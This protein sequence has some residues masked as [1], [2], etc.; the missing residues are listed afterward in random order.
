MITTVSRRA[1]FGWL[2]LALLLLTT[3]VPMPSAADDGVR[4]VAQAE[5][6]R[7]RDLEPKYRPREP[8]PPEAYNDDYFFAMTRGVAESPIHPAGKV[9]LYVF[10]VPIDLVLLPF[11]AIGGLFG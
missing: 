9:A 2:A 10:S 3:G 11:A 6:T 8:E 7:D 4:V 1:A 5:G